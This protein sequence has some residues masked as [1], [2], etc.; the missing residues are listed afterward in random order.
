MS[1]IFVCKPEKLRQTKKFIGITMNNNNRIRHI[2]LSS[3]FI[4]KATFAV[5]GHN[6]HKEA[7]K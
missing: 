4:Y 2:I 3:A 5:K 6:K 1:T 7:H